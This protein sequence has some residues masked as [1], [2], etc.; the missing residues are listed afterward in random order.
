MTWAR[1]VT[2]NALWSRSP[3]APLS[4]DPG[5]ELESIHGEDE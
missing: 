5:V 2:K 1:L 3:G 4:H